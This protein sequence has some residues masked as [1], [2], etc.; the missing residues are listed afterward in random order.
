MLKLLDVRRGLGVSDPRDMIFAHV[1]FAS[2]G[3]HKDLAV[4][5]SKFWV[6]VYKSFAQYLAY[7]HGLAVVLDCV[8]GHNAAPISRN[9]PS[10]VPNWMQKGPGRYSQMMDRRIRGGSQQVSIWDAGNESLAYLVELSDLVL[11]T[12][13][14]L[15]LLNLSRDSMKKIQSK[16]QS[17]R[18]GHRGQQL[19]LEHGDIASLWFEVYQIWH[20]LVKNDNILTEQLIPFLATGSPLPMHWMEV[21]GLIKMTYSVPMFL[22]SAFYGGEH[23]LSDR[24]LAR[25]ASGRLAIV[26]ASTQ[27]GDLLIPLIAT[28]IYRSE[29]H[30]YVFHP[31]EKGRPSGVWWEKIRAS[32]DI[33]PGQDWTHISCKYVGGCLLDTTPTHKASKDCDTSMSFF[34]TLD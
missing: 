18:H 10:W 3:A 11:L 13:S 5:Y 25:M 7:Q 34:M 23:D 14:R 9:L 24:V 21:G 31:V 12:S 22:W 26:P 27:E 20:G 6:Q 29:N 2:D 33:D 30:P 8:S 1:G 17:I 16:M 19:Y 32:G 28:E 4:D 15:S